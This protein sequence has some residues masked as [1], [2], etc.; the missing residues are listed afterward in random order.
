[1]LLKRTRIVKNV[2]AVVAFNI[3]QEN[4]ITWDKLLSLILIYEKMYCNLNCIEPLK[5]MLSIYFMNEVSVKKNVKILKNQCIV[6]RFTFPDL[7]LSDLYVLIDSIKLNFI[8]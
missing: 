8:T 5:I 1:M 2:V 3:L 4:N 7:I 6:Y